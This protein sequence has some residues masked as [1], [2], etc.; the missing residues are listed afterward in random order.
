MNEELP[1]RF[2]GVGHFQQLSTEKGAPRNWLIAFNSNIGVSE[3]L[4]PV[5]PQTVCKTV[6]FKHAGR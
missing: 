3:N 2:G 4:W 5:S 6:V 1:A